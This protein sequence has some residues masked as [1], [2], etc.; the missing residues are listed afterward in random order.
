ME[1]KTWTRTE[2]EAMIREVDEDKNGEIDFE[3]FCRLMVR[4]MEQ[5]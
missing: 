3:E 5:N 1:T 2:I 4:Q